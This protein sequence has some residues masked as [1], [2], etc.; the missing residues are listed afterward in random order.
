MRSGER[1]GGIQPWG[2]DPVQ[3]AVA[4]VLVVLLFAGVAAARVH[5]VVWNERSEASVLEDGGTDADVAVTTAAVSAITA[6]E[7]PV[8]E[9]FTIGDLAAGRVPQDV[10]D[11]FWQSQL[12]AI[13]AAPCPEGPA[14]GGTTVTLHLGADDAWTARLADAAEARR[15]ACAA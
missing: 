2:Q 13:L 6:A 1:S 5:G 8:T 7:E 14:A 12:D 3:V 4:L 9:H 11:R 15:A 10:Q